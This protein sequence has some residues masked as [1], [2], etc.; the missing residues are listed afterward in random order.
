MATLATVNKNK[1]SN[2]NTKR[3]F[4]IGGVVIVVA[5][6]AGVVTATRATGASPNAVGTQST[7]VV[8]RG[9]IVSAVSGAGTIQAQDTV[10]LAFQSSGTVAQVLVE[11]GDA[12]TQGQT[13]AVLDTRKLESQVAAAQAQL[14]TAQAQLAQ[15]QQG[16]GTPAEIASAQ[17]AVASAQANYDKVIA[18]PTDAELKSAQADLASAQ[19]AYV[20]AVKASETSGKDLESLKA[21]IEKAQVN[22]QQAQSAYDQIGGASN[23]NIG[24]MKQSKDLQNATIDYQ[25][26]LANYQAKLTTNGPDAQKQIAS[27]Q[28]SVASAQKRLDDLTVSES[29]RA[30]ALASLESAKSTL[31]KLTAAASAN[32]LAIAQ[33]NVKSAQESLNQAKL[34]LENAKLTAPFNG[35]ITDVR[36]AQ[37]SN[38]T[39][40]AISM[41]NRDTLHVDLKLNETD[42][43][44]VQ[45]NM[46]VQLTIDSLKNWNAQGI[47]EYIAPAGVSTNGV[48]TYAVR[49]SL[50]DT[51]P[52]VKVGMTANVDITIEQKDNVLVIPN[53]ALL[54]QGTGHVVEIV[55]ADNTTQKVPV[56]IGLSDG[57][58]TEITGGI[59]EGT[60]I[61]ALPGTKT[62]QDSG[63]PGPF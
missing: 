22:L 27:A 2:T 42:V 56:T 49:V 16:N 58:Q 44:R 10:D 60:K 57:A 45:D 12:V 5:L 23:P 63:L 3:W 30:S 8:G 47:V 26:A 6:I 62:K 28:A 39:G 37:G 9:N 15:K 36:I 52:R 53:T 13:L 34:N 29:E 55:N 31:A 40:A 32:D 35:V 24:M 7:L 59:S 17:A 1:K 41:M 51:D 25:Q 48:A 18:G 50:P 19:A 61:I 33:A 4:I 20:S 38:A 54:P 43:V 14:E 46:P 11:E 21:A